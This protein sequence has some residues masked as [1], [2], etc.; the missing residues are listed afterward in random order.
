V[1]ARLVSLVLDLVPGAVIDRTRRI[2]VLAP[3]LRLV[4]GVVSGPLHGRVIPI[5]HGPAKGLVLLF[6]ETSAVWA[7]GKTELPVQYAL[8]R[9]VEPGAVFFDI[10]ANVGFFTLLGARLVGPTGTVVAFEPHVENAERLRR[11]VELNSFSN[12][13]VVARAVSDSSGARILDSRHSA[14]AA[15]V[16]ADET[17]TVEGLA[18]VEASSLD[19]FLAQRPELEPDLVKIDAEGHE[20]EIVR[21]MLQTLRL[22]SPLLVCEMH[23]RDRDFAA[24]LET[25]GYL[26]TSVSRSSARLD[27]ARPTHVL[28]APRGHQALRTISEPRR[29]AA[30]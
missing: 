2:P 3:V 15:L 21:G 4:L 20:V 16:P 10:G 14:T 5:A 12:V 17:G 9:L 24:A 1:L 26:T 18:R 27:R 19:D 7:S 8:E 30:G 13:D 25:A 28:A 23:G 11:N 29:S 22:Y 6:D